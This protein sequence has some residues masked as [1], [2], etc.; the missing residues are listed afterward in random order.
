MKKTTWV[1]V[2]L[3]EYEGETWTKSCLGKHTANE[4]FRD[5]SSCFE[6][7]TKANISV[8]HVRCLNPLHASMMVNSTYGKP[9]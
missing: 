3:I 2:F 6:E 7:P 1:T 5:F 8:K 4:Y 9:A